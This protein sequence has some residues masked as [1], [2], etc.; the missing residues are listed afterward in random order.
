MGAVL[1]AASPGKLF[2]VATPIGNL[3]DLSLRAAK[4]LRDADLVLCEDTRVSR[5]LLERH[6][7]GARLSSLHEHNEERRVAQITRQLRE[8][9]VI[10]LVSDA[11]T[12]AVS[13]PGRR[14]VA[15]AHAAGVE[16]VSVPGANAAV[17]ALAGAG[18][19]ADRF[20][21]EGF[22]PPRRAARRARLAALQGEVRTVVFYEAPHRIA[23]TL[24]DLVLVFGAARGAC[25]AKELT[26]VH[27]RFVCDSLER[28]RRWLAG[29]AGRRKGEFVI[30]VAGA[31]REPEGGELRIAPL[32]LLAA[33]LEHLP[34][35]AAADV[36]AKLG[37]GK[38][39]RLYRAAVEAACGR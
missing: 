15:A 3:G 34:P 36:V 14:L 17:A 28:V 39:N 31:A 22:L 7:I 4:I 2:V 21:F 30:V 16:V 8:G 33:L 32:K 23:A 26:K 5:R 10:A 35:R 1:Q 29:D 11:G 27:E 20:L 13:D 12:P 37:G 19:D 9:R 38:R 18:M 24:E 25:L 6:G